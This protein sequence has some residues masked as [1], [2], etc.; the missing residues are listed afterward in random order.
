[1]NVVVAEQHNIS[2]F[3]FWK[4]DTV[5]KGRRPHVFHRSDAEFRAVDA[6]IFREREL[7]VKKLFVKLYALSHSPENQ[8]SVDK[9]QFGFS[10]KDTHRSECIVS[11]VLYLHVITSAH[12]VDV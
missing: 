8:V 10:N 5:C 12:C 11:F 2:H 7:L 3:I 9:L 1:M 6:V 4:Q